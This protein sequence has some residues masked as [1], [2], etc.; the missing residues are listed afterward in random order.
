MAFL[1][2]TKVKYVIGKP[3]FGVKIYFYKNEV[4][5]NDS[6]VEKNKLEEFINNLPSDKPN[7]Y[8]LCFDKKMNYDN[9][10]KSK[11]FINSIRF[12]VPLMNLQNE[13]FIY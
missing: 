6:L 5:V 10:I 8:F 1:P 11:V 4:F 9:Y 7:K 13:E 2:F 3:E 12:P